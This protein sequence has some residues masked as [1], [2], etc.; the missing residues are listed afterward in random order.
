MTTL[1]ERIRAY[2]AA[3]D[4]VLV[5]RLPVIVRVDGCRFSH[6]TK[7]Q[8]CA[9]PFDDKLAAALI[10]ATSSTADYIEDCVFAYTQSD[11]ATFVLRNDRSKE[12][13]PWFGNRLQKLSSIIASSVST[14]F[15]QYYFG[16]GG[17]LSFTPALFDA[18]VFVVPS[19]DEALNT[20]IYRQQDGTKNSISNACYC[21][22]GKKLG[23]KTAHKLLQSKNTSERLD[24]LLD[25]TG[26]NWNDYPTH[27]KRGVACYK[28]QVEVNGTQRSKWKVDLE[29]PILA[30]NRTWALERLNFGRREDDQVK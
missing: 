28:E 26:L 16:G 2:E 27:F 6:F 17:I 20:L 4:T 1:A 23:N 25:I 21:E 15:N 7:H 14:R 18:R 9:R 24:L 22:L 13:Q 19:I 8:H 12:S 3:T 5:N 29:P 11:E 30:E 10:Y